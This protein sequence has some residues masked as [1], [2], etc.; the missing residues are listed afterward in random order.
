LEVQK[1]YAPV[2]ILRAILAW[3]NIWSLVQNSKTSPTTDLEK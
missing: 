1:Y 2:V 3:G